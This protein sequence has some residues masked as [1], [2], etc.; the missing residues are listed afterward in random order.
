MKFTLGWLKDHLD[1]NATLEEIAT[2]LTAL[3]LE[4]EGVQD[5]AATF[6]AFKVAHV[7]SAEKHPDADRL[8]V[9]V[10]DTGS[11]KLQ[12]V[13]GAPNARA[14]MKAV[15]APAGSFIPGTGIT[16]KK[17]VIRG[18]ESNGMLVSE[19]EMGLSDEH[20]GIIDLPADTTIGTAFADIYGLNDPVIEIAL[21]PDRADCAGVRGIARDL[22]AAGLGTLKKL[23]ESAAPGTAKSPINVHL[24]F[25]ADSANA[26]PLFIGRHITGVKNGPS[27]KWLQDR[28]KAVGLRPISVLVDITNYISLDLCR[29]LH[30][31]DADK[32]KGDIH[33]RLAKKG[34]T[35]DA[36]NDKTYTLDD[37]M[38][39]V[40]DDS[41]VLGLGGIIG[42]ASTGCADDTTNVFL[43]VAY[44]DPARTAKTGRALQ[45]DSDARYRFERGIDPTFTVPA[46][47]IATR[48]ILELCGGTASAVITAGAV[49]VW[50]RPIAFDPTLTKKMTGVELPAAEQFKILET[51]GFAING[52][53]V[54]PPS[55]RGDVEGKA[56]L[57]EEVV[58]VNGYDKIPAISLQKTT[59]VTQN[60][61]TTNG[62]R[63]RHARTAL[64]ARGMNECVTWSFLPAAQ[65]ALF[66]SNDSQNAASLRLLNPISADLDQMRPSV[67]PNLIAAAGRNA[68]RGFADTALFEVGPA[69]ASVKTDGGTLVAAGIRHGKRGPRHWSGPDA[70]RPADTFDAKAD[71][72]AVLTACGLPEGSAQ[73]GRDAPEW[74]H[75]GRSG[76]LRLGNKIIAR[77][78]ELHPAVL[79]DMDVKGPVAAFEVMLES[80]PQPKKKGTAKTLLSLPPLQPVSRDFAF[81]VDDAVEADAILRT[82]RG[83]DK[84]LIA[85]VS[86]FDVYKGKGVEDGKKSVAIAVTLQPREQTLTDADLE[87]LARKI[88]DAVTA[89]TGG[90]L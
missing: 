47:E 83:V 67:L 42:G 53:T 44:F 37:F 87:S 63:A 6:A 76:T 13:C 54:T 73:V 11:E 12:V 77:F 35:L 17:G 57:V 41:G 39:A 75:P 86:V 61:E 25:E 8:R 30:V 49:P 19:R 29:P 3:G 46:A 40:C 66:G 43:E 51:L 89:K 48:M 7:V 70:A 79:E 9:C 28:L 81:L 5:R 21:T 85:D 15:F 71:A 56:D 55:W 23:G 65:A 68:A 62:T 26:C 14:G 60:A 33:I 52:Q 20:E 38:T 1:T 32:L 80:I 18:Q 10:V 58:R 22:A 84:N 27:P 69:F 2:A 82:V 4:V 16:L 74:Y 24:K 59:T 34:E 45:I 72:L 36:L 78:G 64:A 88:T 50:E 90:Q 31:F